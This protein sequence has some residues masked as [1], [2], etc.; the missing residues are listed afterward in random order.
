MLFIKKIHAGNLTG[1]TAQWVTAVQVWTLS[2]NL[3]HRYKKPGAAMHYCNLS[4]GEVKKRSQEDYGPCWLWAYFLL[5]WET[6]IQTNIAESGRVEYPVFFP[7][8]WVCI[9]T[10]MCTRT[11]QTCHTHIFTHKTSKSIVNWV[12]L[13][14]LI[15]GNLENVYKRPSMKFDIIINFNT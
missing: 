9:C 10:N 7:G 5:Q 1:V 11:T 13:W 4:P 3:L 2:S 14:Q 15:K 8:H 12:F 6:L